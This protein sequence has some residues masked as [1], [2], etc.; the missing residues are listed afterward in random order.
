MLATSDCLDSA[1]SVETMR[2]RSTEWLEAR[3]RAVV[4]EIRR[5]QAEEHS[6]L[7]V[8][9]DHHGAP[10]GIEQRTSSLSPKL[11]HAV[12]VRDGH[13]RCGHCDLRYGLQ[14]HHRRPRSWGGTDELS[15]L[16]AVA[17]VHHPIL[18]PNGPYALVGNPN[19]PDGLHLVH[20][21][22]LTRE[23]SEPVG[24]PRPRGRP[25]DR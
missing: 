6:I 5:L 4:A 11:Q 17:S 9:V 2:S 3:R 19:R 24:L 13:C 25:P 15:N 23:Q 21:N 8:L 20:I 7:L 1:G 16:A 14:V 12:L 18:I 22:D 10:V